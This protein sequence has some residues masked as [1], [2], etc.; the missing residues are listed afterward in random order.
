MIPGTR[1]GG[2]W[3]GAA[4]DDTSNILY[5]RSN[6]APEIQTIIKQDPE[7]IAGLPL[8]DQGRR[9]YN[10]YCQSCHGGNRKGVPPN[11]SLAD[12]NLHQTRE[13]V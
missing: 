2:N 11:P 9:L 4:Y 1:G 5:I 10:I 8:A 3:G 7:A 12:I 6:N 13:V